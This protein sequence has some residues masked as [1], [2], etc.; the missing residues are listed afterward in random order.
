MISHYKNM[1][2]LLTNTTVWSF[3]CCTL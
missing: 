3:V 2:S 1:T